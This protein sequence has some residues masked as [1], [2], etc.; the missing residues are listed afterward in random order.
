MKIITKVDEKN[1]NNYV[2]TYKH[3]TGI[4]SNMG[5]R[6]KLSITS[7]KTGT[8]VENKSKIWSTKGKA[9]ARMKKIFEK[10]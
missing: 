5:K 3:L 4:I 2:Y 7:S 6:W 10:Y 8:E 9:E 1:I